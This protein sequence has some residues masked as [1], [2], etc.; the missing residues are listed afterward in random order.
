[1]ITDTD[2]RAHKLKYPTFDDER[3]KAWLSS[4]QRRRYFF[5]DVAAANNSLRRAERRQRLAEKD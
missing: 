1:M 3:L 2:I 4:N 5:K